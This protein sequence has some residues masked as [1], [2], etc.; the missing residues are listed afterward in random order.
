MQTTDGE[1]NRLLVRVASL[2]RQ[3]RFWKIAV[4]LMILATCF[5]FTANVR[6]QIDP[7]VREKNTTVEARTFL[8]RDSVGNMRGKMTVDG[9]RHPVL[10]FYD[11]D[12]KVIWSTESHVIPTK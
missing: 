4:L 10:E 6:A 5:S 2:E 9:D 1:Y 12:G 7:G 8:L 11:M 3:G